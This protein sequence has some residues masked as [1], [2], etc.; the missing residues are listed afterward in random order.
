VVA[1]FGEGSAEAAQAGNDLAVLYK[2]WGRFDDGLRLYERALPTVIAYHGE[3]SLEAA[4]LYHNLGGILHSKGDFRAAEQPGRK[5]WE[6]SRRLLG[7]DAP[8]TQMDA[9]AYAAILDGL[10]RYEE[11]EAIYR[12]ALATLV[13][14]LGPEHYEVA[15][16]LQNLAAVL[17]ARG[18]R[19]EAERFYRRCLA[20][21]ENLLGHDHPD[22]ALTYNNLSNLL[23]AEGRYSE[24]LPH[25][26]TAVEIL[27]KHLPQDHP[28]LV[29]ARTNLKVATA[30]S[31]P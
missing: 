20:I 30:G 10:E 12:A 21:Q 8:R 1:E 17:C 14:Q 11:S 13:K 19:H 15:S 2:Y 26:L 6:I 29:R 4:T 5:A 31:Q 25:L 16:T 24:A 27:Q 18:K 28:H 9:V 23:N 3:D 22:V 7:E